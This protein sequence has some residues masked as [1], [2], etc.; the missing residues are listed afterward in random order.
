MP[1]Q[2]VVA[3]IAVVKNK[4]G[5]ILFTKRSSKEKFSPGLWDFPGGS[6]DFLESIE[7]GTKR[8]CREE[9]GIEIDLK[10]LLWFR[11]QESRTRENCEFIVFYFLCEP[12]SEEV[13]LSHEHEEYRWATIEEMKSEPTIFWMKEFIKKVEA[14][15]IKL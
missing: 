5:K 2:T 7:D 8:E 4:E 13:T 9:T 1:Y 3:C 14:G 11:A 12:Q 15:E 10:E 6:K